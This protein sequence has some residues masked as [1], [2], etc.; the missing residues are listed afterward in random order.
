MVN[1]MSEATFQIPGT[2][3]VALE[4]IADG[5]G[6]D[7][8]TF[9][10]QSIGLGLNLAD[11]TIEAGGEAA[12]LFEQPDSTYTK[13]MIDFSTVPRPM[14]DESMIGFE[15]AL[16]YQKPYELVLP[17]LVVISLETAAEAMTTDRVSFME[18]SVFF[19]HQWALV[20][21]WG[22]QILIDD[23]GRE[24]IPYLIAEPQNDELV[25]KYT[26]EL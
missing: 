2:N 10:G 26:I 1:G 23:T 18:A 6:V 20:R 11:L 9:L 14:L 17:S 16:D 24:D 15:C 13:Y 12:V 22:G 25:F 5:A 4:A 3:V 21:Q 19:R 8:S 7:V